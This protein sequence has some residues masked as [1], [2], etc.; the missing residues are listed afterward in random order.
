MKFKITWY[1]EVKDVPAE[2]VGTLEWSLEKL[3]LGY[4]INLAEEVGEEFENDTG[5]IVD[6]GGDDDFYELDLADCPIADIGN[7]PQ[8]LMSDLE[9]KVSNVVSN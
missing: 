3:S 8:R 2:L 6:H 7:L 4:C 5:Y 1:D 9:K